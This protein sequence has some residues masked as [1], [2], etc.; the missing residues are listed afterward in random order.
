MFKR[1]IAGALIFG[2][3]ALAPPAAHAQMRCAERGKLITFLLEKF[4]ENLSG[5][6]L[7]TSNVIIELW[8]SS[9]TGT[10]TILATTA[11]GLSCVIASGSHWHM[12]DTPAA[13][14]GPLM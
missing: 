5:G 1:L 14:T 7:Q 6:G 11:G 12:D 2:M 8:V 4:S 10:F 9:E 13:K 3:A